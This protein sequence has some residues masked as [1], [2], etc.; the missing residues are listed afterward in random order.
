VVSLRTLKLGCLKKRCWPP[1]PVLAVTVCLRKRAQFSF[2]LPKPLVPAVARIDVENE[3]IPFPTGSEP[4]VRVRPFCPP[5]FYLIAIRGCVLDAVWRAWMLA[6]TCTIN[7]SARTTSLYDCVQ[8]DNGQVEV[9]I[10]K[11]LRFL[12]NLSSQRSLQY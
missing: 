2:E 4:N 3:D 12:G 1:P 5:T 8:R 7:T 11:G 6:W 10:F 9:G